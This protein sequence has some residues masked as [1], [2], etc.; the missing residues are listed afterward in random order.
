MN[1]RLKL[2]SRSKLEGRSSPLS[3][4][5][6]EAAVTSKLPGS[7]PL[8]RGREAALCKLSRPKLKLKL[9]QAQCLRFFALKLESSVLEGLV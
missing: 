4:P 1:A 3:T 5:P 7:R 6:L 8:L 9:C 2:V